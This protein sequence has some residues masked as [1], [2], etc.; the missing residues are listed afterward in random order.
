MA[1]LMPFGYVCRED[2]LLERCTGR[3]VLHLGFLGETLAALD[4]R[5]RWVASP[6]SLHWRMGRTAQR[7]VGVDLD[8]EAIGAL[9]QAGLEDVYAA[10][11]ECLDKSELP[12]SARFSVIVAGDL[13]EHLSNPGRM[14]ES[15]KAF[16]APGGVLI[17]TTPNAYGLPNYLRFLRGVFREG[18]DHVQSYSQFTLTHLLNRHGWVAVEM[19]TCHQERASRMSGQMTFQLGKRLLDRAPKLGGT[20]L[21]VCRLQDPARS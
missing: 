2:F 12:R 5:L 18:A 10:N 9:R 3:D 8:G 14:L 13:I 17:L 11:V 15:I 19:H 6:Q 20:L 16:L 21:V 4:E 1:Q 7:V